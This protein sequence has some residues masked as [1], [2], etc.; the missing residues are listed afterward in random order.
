LAYASTEAKS[1]SRDDRDN[2]YGRAKHQVKLGQAVCRSLRL[3]TGKY[4][5]RQRRCVADLKP[6]RKTPVAT[7]CERLSIT[8]IFRA[9]AT[10]W[11]RS[12]VKQG[13]KLNA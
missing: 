1:P 3:T 11:V 4:K 5:H 13:I 10:L 12:Q 6:G 9:M 2:T 8:A 7:F